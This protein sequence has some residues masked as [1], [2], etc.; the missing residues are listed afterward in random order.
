MT[1]GCGNGTSSRAG[2]KQS[3]LNGL[4]LCRSGTV[5]Q[6]IDPTEAG[7]LVDSLPDKEL[8]SYDKNLYK[9]CF[10]SGGIKFPVSIYIDAD[11]ALEDTRN[12]VTSKTFTR[13][14]DSRFQEA[15]AQALN[16]FLNKSET[17][18]SCKALRLMMEAIADGQQ[19]MKSKDEEEERKRRLTSCLRSQ[20]MSFSLKDDAPTILHQS[21]IMNV[22]KYFTTDN[23]Q[24]LRMLYDKYEEVVNNLIHVRASDEKTMNEWRKIWPE[25]IFCP[26]RGEDVLFWDS[27][28]RR[29]FSLERPR[30][31]DF[32][33]YVSNAE[34]KTKLSSQY[35]HFFSLTEVIFVPSLDCVTFGDITDKD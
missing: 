5:V 15:L 6:A 22:R 31:T 30:V 3:E 10:A 8:K 9:T 18:E 24:Q 12:R 7:A 11:F 33:P 1:R 19:T 29:P 27:A 28:D 32:S 14:K 20:T 35:D 17:D 25:Q 23:E 26:Q 21:H 2:I 4:I 13:M 16:Y 34:F